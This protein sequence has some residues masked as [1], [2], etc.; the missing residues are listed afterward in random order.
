[1][2]NVGASRRTATNSCPTF[3]QNDRCGQVA[4]TSPPRTRC[5]TGE[6][7]G[8]RSRAPAPSTTRT[9]SSRC[10]S[11]SSSIAS[12]ERCCLG[13]DA[14]RPA[15]P[16][17]L[18]STTFL[19]ER[20]AR[21]G[22]AEL[23]ADAGTAGRHFREYTAGGMAT[24]A[25]ERLAAISHG[26]YDCI[27]QQLLPT[28]PCSR[29]RRWRARRCGAGGL[30]GAKRGRPGDVLLLLR[31]TTGDLAVVRRVLDGE[32]DG[33][34]CLALYTYAWTSEGGEHHAQ[35]ASVRCLPRV[36]TGWRWRAGSA[37]AEDRE[38]SP[39]DRRAGGPAGRR[40]KR[41]T[42]ARRRSVCATWSTSQEPRIARARRRR[43]TRSV[44]RRVVANS[45][46]S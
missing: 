8:S 45:A 38:A 39:R 22:C 19:N 33:A 29:C 27:A 37:L 24:R 12:Q 14:V 5:S 43:Q 32:Q 35:G 28:T 40:A 26:A 42:A 20:A 34:P 30:H 15:L 9:S 13:N 6:R 1:M 7:P 10:S 44:G 18:P 16:E 41:T 46:I 4:D 17:V 3:C 25:V 21:R 2:G 23:S 36:G 31:W 11:R